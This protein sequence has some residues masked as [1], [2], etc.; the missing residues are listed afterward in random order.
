MG[1]GQHWGGAQ[2]GLQV[3]LAQ[4]GWAVAFSPVESFVL[5]PG[6]IAKQDNW[7]LKIHRKCFLSQRHNCH[8]SKVE[9]PFHSSCLPSLLLPTESPAAA[10]GRIIKEGERD[11]ERARERKE[12]IQGS[13]LC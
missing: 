5:S 7:C 3:G 11:R 4:D 12:E 1:G 9:L 13:A 6:T 8:D 2:R 10:A